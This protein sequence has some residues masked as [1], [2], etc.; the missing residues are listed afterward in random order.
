MSV[1]VY[2]MDI[3]FLGNKNNISFFHSSGTL[4]SETAMIAPLEMK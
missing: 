4:P 3:A 1:V 2:V